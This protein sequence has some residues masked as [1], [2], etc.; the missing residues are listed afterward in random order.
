[1]KIHHLGIAVKNIETSAVM[2][3]E[4][5]GWEQTGSLIYDPVQSVNI[6]F[7]RDSHG[8]RF[9]LLEPVG[10]NSPVKKLLERRIGLYHI[11]YEVQ[12]I[13][14]KIKELTAKGFL[15]ISGPVGAVAFN[16]NLIA[17][18]INRD[19]LIIELVEQ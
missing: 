1:M 7:M 16:D 19:N 9:E 4:S 2:Y 3:N 18:L 12:D 6:L 15:L 17:F 13:H 8:A 10:N 11:C 14:S 5:L